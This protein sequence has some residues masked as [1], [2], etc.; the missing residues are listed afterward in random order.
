M[1]STINFS[2]VKYV[3]SS[4]CFYPFKCDLDG[5]QDA[6]T[7]QNRDDFKERINNCMSNSNISC[8]FDGNQDTFTVQNSDITI[9]VPNL[10]RRTKRNKKRPA[11]NV[12]IISGLIF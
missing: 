10:V 8:D 7:A 1:L 3:F 4:T 2:D 11:Q 6:F 12:I 5:N 9:F